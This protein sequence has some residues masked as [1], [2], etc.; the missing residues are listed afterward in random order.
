MF[1]V[2]SSVVQSKRLTSLWVEFFFTQHC[3]QLTPFGL[4]LEML[5]CS[6]LV[7]SVEYFFVTAL[8]SRWQKGRRKLGLPCQV[9]TKKRQAEKIKQSTHETIRLIYVSN[10]GIERGNTA[11]IWCHC[12]GKFSHINLI[13]MKV[14]MLWHSPTEN[15]NTNTLATSSRDTCTQ[16]LWV[17][18]EMLLITTR[19]QDQRK[20]VLS[21]RSRKE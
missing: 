20:N 17:F 7:L 11:S 12:H 2:A 6:D 10:F 1:T 21:H 15:Y 9:F 14:I 16:R 3:I 18:A 5:L 13:M 8:H 19:S 4:C